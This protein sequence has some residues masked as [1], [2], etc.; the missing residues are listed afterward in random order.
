LK[1]LKGEPYLHLIRKW[2]KSGA[3]SE[4]GFEPTREGTPQ[5]G[6]ISPLLANVALH[7]MECLFGLYNRNGNYTNPSMRRGRNKNISLFRFAD[8]FI[9][10]APSRQILQEYVVPKIQDFLSGL[11]L[12]LNEAKTHIRNISEGFDFLG[13]H[14]RR[15]HRKDGS[16]KQFLYHPTRKRMDR[17]LR[18]IKIWLRKSQHLSLQDI[19]LGL[20][21]KIR[22]FCNYFKWSNAHKSFA[23]LSHRLFRTMWNWVR[24]R[25]QRKR[26][27][28]W[29][30]FHY[31]RPRGNKQWLFHFKGHE[32][33]DPNG[34]KVKWWRRPGVRIHTSPFDPRQQT[35]WVNRKKYKAWANP[36]Q[37]EIYT[38][39][40]DKYISG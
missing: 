19:I 28:K 37:Y 31:W 26:G 4:I 33:L 7:G 6:V 24:H 9:V 12:E 20:N 13:F 18:K 36:T 3:I 39:G 23:Y 22:G 11:G 25:H 32:L 30:K 17:F 14:F 35:Y 8:D 34:L 29:L 15:F 5:G 16:I 2:L 21:R 27:A 38:T 40:M 1:K 10:I